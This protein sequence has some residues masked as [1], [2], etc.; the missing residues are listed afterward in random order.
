[1]AKRE[2]VTPLKGQ[3]SEAWRKLV[4]GDRPNWNDSGSRV[5]ESNWIRC[6]DAASGILNAVPAGN[7]FSSV[8]ATTIISRNPSGLWSSAPRGRPRFPE[9]CIF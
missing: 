1:M 7:R 2:K 4:L 5:V 8:T 9:V 3:P 6:E